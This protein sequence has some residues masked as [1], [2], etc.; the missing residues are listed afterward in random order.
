KGLGFQFL[1]HVERTRVLALLVDGASADPAAD[2]ALVE[3]ELA[4]YSQALADKPRVVV[5]TKSDL[6]PEDRER[7]A[8]GLEGGL[9]IRAHAGT[10]IRELLETLWNRIAAEA[11]SESTQHE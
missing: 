11:V 7:G 4:A 5:R 10:G 8:S 3:S 6:I 9:V 1:R 2:A